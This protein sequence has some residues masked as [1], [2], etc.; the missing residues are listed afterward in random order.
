MFKDLQAVF[1]YVQLII[2]SCGFPLNKANS[3]EKI[4]LAERFLCVKH[5]LFLV[6]AKKGVCV[7]GVV[8]K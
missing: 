8:R 3:N 5:H 6:I 7:G 2:P 4:R 1:S